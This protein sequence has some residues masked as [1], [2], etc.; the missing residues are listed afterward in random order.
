MRTSL[1][2]ELGNKSSA[3]ARRSGSELG[4]RRPLSVTELYRSARPRTTTN[5]PSATFTPVVFASRLA[6][7]LA[8]VEAMNCAPS[9]SV[10]LFNSVRR[11]MAPVD[12]VESTISSS[13]TTNSSN[14]TTSA[15]ISRSICFTEPA[16]TTMP[17]RRSRTKPSLLTRRVYCP[18]GRSLMKKLPSGPELP[19]TPVPSTIT[20]APLTG[21][22]KSASRMLPRK[23]PFC[24][25]A[26]ASPVRAAARTKAKMIHLPATRQWIAASA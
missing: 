3:T 5:L 13:A 12:A 19:P 16:E 26:T 9:T 11:V 20:V 1:I 15:V 22:E 7:L 8:P 2:T 6:A 24:D 14:S 23:A 21:T 4:I 10:K 17:L 25:C 18:G